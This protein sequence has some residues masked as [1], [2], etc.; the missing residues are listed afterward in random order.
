[1]NKFMKNKNAKDKFTVYFLSYSSFILFLITLFSVSFALAKNSTTFIDTKITELDNNMI[2]IT[3]Q[4][5]QLQVPES[6]TNLLNDLQQGKVE[7]SLIIGS[8]QYSP[9]VGQ[10]VDVYLV[11]SSNNHLKVCTNT[12]D[13]NGRFWCLIQLENP[14]V[15][16]NIKFN[17]TTNLYKTEANYPLSITP[18]FPSFLGLIDDKWFIIFFILGVLVAALYAAGKKPLDA[19]DIT[20][21]KKI[22]GIKPAKIIKL[23]TDISQK[24]YDYKYNSLSNSLRSVLIKT[25]SASILNKMSKIESKYKDQPEKKFHTYV[26]LVALAGS[27]SKLENSLK[28]LPNEIRR[29][30]KKKEMFILQKARANDE[31]RK[32][33][34]SQIKDI[35]ER[36]KKYEKEIEQYVSLRRK[37]APNEIIKKIGFKDIEIEKA[38]QF[39]SCV[40][41]LKED[42]SSIRQKFES[43]RKRKKDINSIFKDLDEEYNKLNEKYQEEVK[44]IFG[45][46]NIGD[47]ISKTIAT[48]I[49]LNN[50]KLIAEKSEELSEKFDRNQE[51]LSA[52]E[53][54]RGMGF[55]EQKIK[56][57]IE[58]EQRDFEEAK[59]QI[60]DYLEKLSRGHKKITLEKAEDLFNSSDIYAEMLLNKLNKTAQS[61]KQYSS[62]EGQNKE[63]KAFTLLI[64]LSLLVPATESIYNVLHTGEEKEEKEEVEPKFEEISTT[65]SPKES[66]SESSNEKSEESE[67]NQKY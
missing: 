62:A 26:K 39:V 60:E 1:M 45:S 54:R 9:V 48:I 58:E 67:E 5:V 32:E 64:S 51:V 35:D 28:K 33:I 65:E 55:I 19:F 14:N 42:L 16:I 3:S 8:Y 37:I 20:T 24:L 31:K 47:T 59:L 29:L 2:S 66:S 43:D 53:K 6:K 21:P 23:K 56:E 13:T 27:W 4:L 25:A 18:Q 7:D 61:L 15:F 49:D 17:G 46:S 10:A 12:T 34:D 11:D 38:E 57:S 40:Q 41:N 44:E 50:K 22:K 52:W 63:N 30:Q 36:I